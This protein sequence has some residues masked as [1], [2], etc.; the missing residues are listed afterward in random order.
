MKHQNEKIFF[1]DEL[2]VIAI[3]TEERIYRNMVCDLITS[4]PFEELK[5]IATMYHVE[6]ERGIKLKTIIET[7]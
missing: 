7:K 1:E 2:R 6:Q 4:M 3:I 5:K